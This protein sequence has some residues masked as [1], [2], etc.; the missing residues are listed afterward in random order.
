[1]LG[2]AHPTTDLP[3]NANDAAGVTDAQTNT[4]A[5]RLVGRPTGV[6]ALWLHPNAQH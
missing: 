3:K 2:G 1:V 4:P 6:F 5:A